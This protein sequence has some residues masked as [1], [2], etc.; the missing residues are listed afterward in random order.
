MPQILRSVKGLSLAPASSQDN[1][2]L[3]D[4][5]T[6]SLSKP[7]VFR[8]NLKISYRISIFVQHNQLPDAPQ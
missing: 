1:L 5:S 8:L 3:R 6:L 2:A 7:E 4:A